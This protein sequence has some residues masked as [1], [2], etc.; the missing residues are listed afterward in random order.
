VGGDRG[1]LNIYGAMAQKFRGVV[2]SGDNG[3]AKGYSYDER[4]RYTAPP[5][6]L[7]PVTTTYGVSLW[8]EVD[9]VFDESGSY[10]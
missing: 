10:R 5:K 8:V 9:R 6:F 2:R 7:S 4:F 3:Y 1:K